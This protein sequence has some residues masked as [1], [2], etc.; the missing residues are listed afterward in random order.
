MSTVLVT[1]GTGF[2]GS[3]LVEELVRRGDRVRCIVRPTSRLDLLRSLGVELAIGDVD[4]RSKLEEFVKGAD[5]VFHLAGLIRAFRS[6]EYYKVNQ[7]G[8]GRI[9]AACASQTNPP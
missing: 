6:S 8:T 1:G 2:I 4:G 7:Q 5:T 3:H 9:T